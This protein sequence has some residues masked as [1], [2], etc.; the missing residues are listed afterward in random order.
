MLDVDSG[1]IQFWNGTSWS[2]IQAGVASVWNPSAPET[3]ANKTINTSTNTLKTNAGTLGLW[4]FNNAG[5]F[6]FIPIGSANRFLKV[7]SL[8]TGFEFAD[9][10]VSGS[11]DPSGTEAL[12]NKT[13]NF[14]LNTLKQTTP[15]SGDV[16][17]DNGTKF[18]PL[19][20]GANNTFLGVNSSGVVGWYTVAGGGGGGGGSST[21]TRPS[22]TRVKEG[23]YDGGNNLDKKKAYGILE[24]RIVIRTTDSA[25]VRKL[26][27][28]KGPY[29]EYNETTNTSQFNITTDEKIFMREFGSYFLLNFRISA[30]VDF[31]F[32][33]GFHTDMLD[34]FNNTGDFED[35]DNFVF[36]KLENDSKFSILSNSSTANFRKELTTVDFNTNNHTIELQADPSNNRFQWRLDDLGGA[37]NNVTTNIPRT[38]IPLGMFV[39]IDSE[40]GTDHD[41]EIYLIE[42][43]NNLMVT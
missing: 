22:M 2:N 32:Y 9:P 14:L 4:G 15:H 21:V 42:V 38:S 19:T 43:A 18:I 36:A 26:S 12:T 31:D 17:V 33:C 3:F 29:L 5:V 27:P 41:L 8:G 10:A 11:W 7:N 20:R 16:L 40:T 25:P 37:W 35:Q 24:D 6:N 23:W 39:G 1:R 13:L 28:T 30:N 34:D